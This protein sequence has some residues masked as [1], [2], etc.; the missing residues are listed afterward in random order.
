MEDPIEIPPEIRAEVETRA[1]FEA[2]RRGDYAQA[3]RAQE[4]LRE[5]GWHINR[6]QPK[7]RKRKAVTT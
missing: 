7:P 5:M 3:A 1:L 4:R 2:V 6:E